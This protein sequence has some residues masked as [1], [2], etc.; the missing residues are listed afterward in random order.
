VGDSCEGIE[1][2]EEDHPRKVKGVRPKPKGRRELLNLECS[3]ARPLGVGKAKL[4]LSSVKGLVW[5]RV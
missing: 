2:T 1:D 5:V 4:T 3:I